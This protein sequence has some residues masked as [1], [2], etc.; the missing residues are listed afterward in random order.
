MLPTLRHSGPT[1]MF[2]DVSRLFHN[3]LETPSWAAGPKGYP[4]LNVWQDEH[5]FFVQ[6]EL[7][8]LR[9][10]DLDLTVLSDQLKIRGQRPELSD[11]GTSYRHRERHTGTFERSVRIPSPINSDGVAAVLENGVLTITL[12]KAE[13]AKPRKI[14]VKVK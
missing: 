6:A 14:E 12:P 1:D 3:F 8:G 2:R 9:L 4:A 10:E 5:A 11:D 13:E 7:P